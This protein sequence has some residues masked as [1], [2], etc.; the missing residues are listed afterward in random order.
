MSSIDEI[1]DARIHKLKLLKEAGINPY[2]AESRREISLK[3]AIENF[4]TLEIEKSTKWIAGRIM[5]IR[6]QGAIVFVTL[7][8]GTA[9]F[10]GLLKKDIIG[11]EKLEFFSKVADIG[12][13]VEVQGNFFKTNRGEKTLEAKDWGMLSKSLRP[14]PEKWHG[15]QDVEERFRKRYLEIVTDQEVFDRFVLRGNII[16]E[17]RNFFDN[18]GFLEIETPILKNKAGG[19]MALPFITHHNDLDIDMKLRISLEIEHKMIMVG[20]YTGV[21]EIGKN[22]RNEGSDPT[23]IQEFTMMEW[24]SAY[25]TLEDN[26]VWTEK[27]LKHLAKDIVKKSRF[28]VYDKEGASTEVDFEGEWLRV[29]FADLLQKYAHID[30][31]SITDA[32]L[33]NEAVKYGMDKNDLD[34]TSRA[35]MLDFIYKHTARPKLINP[36]FV[37]DYPGD[38]KPLAQQNPDGTALVAQLLIG[39]AEI[40]N[41]YAELVDPLK[42]R[43]LFEKQMA[44]KDAGD[45]EAMEI[46]EDFITAMEHG[47]PPMT[48]FGMGI[49]RLVAIFAEQKNIRDTIFFPIMKPRN[50]D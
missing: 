49:D 11:D 7:N 33:K 39:G 28:T 38:L 10:Q 37:T 48:G 17:I 35:N 16:K 36:T 13:F 22:F 46:D 32:D 26:I 20:G 8:D 21:Y 3:D 14:L 29:K 45:E 25:H 30:M 4:D 44:A 31:G 50:L 15:L 27:L 12:D 41:Q 34:K 2:P 43:E 42:Q 5:S 40:T 1:R 9:T 19:A 6:G 23:H 24:Y 47:M 18:L